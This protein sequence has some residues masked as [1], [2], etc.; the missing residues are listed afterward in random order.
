MN[1]TE[2]TATS[3]S[4]VLLVS[5]SGRIR[6]AYTDHESFLGHLPEA[7]LGKQALRFVHTG[8]RQTVRECLRT[9][10]AAQI[11]VRNSA[12]RWE[13]VQIKALVSA[14]AVGSRFMSVVLDTTPPDSRFPPATRLL[15]D[16]VR[17]ITTARNPSAVIADVLELIAR[18]LPSEKLATFVFEEERQ[19]YTLQAQFG[20]APAAI[21]QLQSM[22][23]PPGQPFGGRV[24]R[25]EVL[26]ANDITQQPY[27]PQELCEQ[28]GIS[29]YVAVPLQAQRR[30]FGVL[31]A[32]RS[33]SGQPFGFSEVEILSAVGRQI[34]IAVEADEALQAEREQARLAESLARFG[35]EALSVIGDS[36]P[37]DAFCRL[38]CEEAGCDFSHIWL[39]DEETSRFTLAGGYGE[40]RDERHVMEALW[41]N[42]TLSVEWRERL[43]AQGHLLLPWDVP[44]LPVPLPPLPR[45]HA[46]PRYLAALRKAGAVIG[47]HCSG[48]RNRRHFKP[49]QLRLLDG[50][51]QLTT[52]ALDHVLALRALEEA[53]RTKSEFV[54][55]MSHELR[56]PLN[57]ILGYSDLLLDGTFGPLNEEQDHTLRRVRLRARELFDLIANTL[58]L[59]R[60]EAGTL[61]VKVVATPVAHLA[62]TVAQELRDQREAKG[63]DLTFDIA[64]EG[65]IWN[66]DPDKLHV[67]LKDLVGNAIKFTERGEVRVQ[68]FS[69]GNHL[70]CKVRDTG[71]GIPQEALPHIF[72]PYKQASAS[73]GSQ[74]GVGLGLFIVRRL[75]EMLG[76]E[77]TVNS[78]VGEESEFTVILPDSSR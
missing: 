40:T 41:L 48:Y 26:V 75:V 2:P 70:V 19:A 64:D 6:A 56:T 7:L 65:L 11:Q 3:R 13:T 17:L 68:M 57:V 30:H 50:I 76:G 42:P 25:G 27:L 46:A 61:A 16:A 22:A 77:I 58:D 31:C 5:R 69:R 63:L 29:A 62:R 4:V 66:T 67:I 38:T 20:L 74:S 33:H 60:I 23:F 39:W 18:L 71:I 53:N 28:L 78:T 36:Q 34:A 10:N 43:S 21:A 15:L 51:A 32:A 45:E 37:L 47:F 73:H 12:N 72:E 54:A 9:G 14:T 24:A 1:G 59:N 35:R 49:A 52:L 8:D 44:S 55:A